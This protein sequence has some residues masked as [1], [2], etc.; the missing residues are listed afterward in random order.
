[1]DITIL[2]L[3]FPNAEFNAPFAGR[4]GRGATDASETGGSSSTSSG[5]AGGTVVAFLVIVGLAC[6]AWYLRRA[7]STSADSP[8]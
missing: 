6:V 5:S 4:G 3:Q 1:M 8:G 2:E 7:Q